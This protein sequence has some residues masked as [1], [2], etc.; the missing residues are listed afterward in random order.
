[1]LLRSTIPL[2][3]WTENPDWWSKILISTR[4]YC[5]IKSTYNDHVDWVSGRLLLLLTPHLSPLF[6]SLP[7]SAMIRLQNRIAELSLE[8]EEERLNLKEMHK[9]RVR[10]NKDREVRQAEIA[11][12]ESK[13]K[14]IQMLKFG[15][16]IDVD[17]LE[18][19]SDRS[20]E[21]EAERTVRV[22]EEEGRLSLYRMQKELEEVQE[23]LARVRCVMNVIEFL[24]SDDN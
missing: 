6:S 23:K 18:A 13:C 9:E 1:M 20:K 17:A 16:L 22:V 12:W 4:T 10:L 2:Y 19:G 21:V 24:I 5:L 8:T 14:N 7:H 3:Y 11:A 15:R